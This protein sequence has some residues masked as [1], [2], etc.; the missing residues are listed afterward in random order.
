MTFPAEFDPS[1]CVLFLGSGF[2]AD[3]KN[4]RNQG[5]PVGNGLKNSILT[6]L[7]LPTEQN[8]DD[9]KDVAKYAVSRRV[10]LLRLLQELYTIT[11]INPNQETILAKNWRRIY[12]TNYDDIVEFSGKKSGIL[13]A[14]KSFSLD[15]QRPAKLPPNSVIHLHGYIHSA[16]RKDYLT[17]LVLDHR[18]YS[19]QAALSSPWWDQFERDIRG[20]QWVFFVGYSLSD[21]AVSK[22]LTKDI[23]LSKATRF[24][25]RPSIND[26]VADRLEGYGAIDTIEVSGFASACASAKSGTPLTELKQLKAFNV[27]DPY[28][29]NKAISRPTPVEIEAFLTRGNYSAHALSSTYPK[30]EFAI[31][32][33]DEIASAQAKLADVRTLVL[34]SRTANGK[35]I[36]AEMLGLALTNAG[37]TCVRYKSHASIPPE[38]I[39]FLSKLP[40]L[41]VFVQ[42]YDDAVEI[43]DQL[44][45]LGDTVKFIVEINTGTDQVRRSEVQGAL[46]K[47]VDRQDLNRLTKLDVSNFQSLLDRAG[48]PIKDFEKSQLLNPELRD[49]L[50]DLLKSEHVR[51]RI[52][53]VIQPLMED[54]EALKIVATACV[55]KAFSIHAGADFIRSVTG[56]DPYGILFENKLLTIEI[57]DVTPDHLAFH[58]AVFC[59]F[60]LKEYVGGTRIRAV[61]CRLAFEAARRK[62]DGDFKNSQRTREARKALGS[63]VQYGRISSLFEGMSDGEKYVTETFEAL[64]DNIYINQEPLFWLQ[65]SIFMQDKSEYGI[66]RKHLETA[67]LRAEASDG[68]RTFQLDTNYLKLIL[69]APKGEDGFP[70]DTEVIF[71]LLDKVKA[72]VLS[73]DHRVHAL[74]VLEDLKTFSINHGPTITAG[75]RQKLSLQCLSISQDLNGLGIEMKTEFGTD[76][77]RFIVED[78]IGI[79]AEI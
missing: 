36:F 12:T 45:E 33:T 3:A 63:L 71:D 60:L 25:M 32:R 15:D 28:K 5:P 46:V 48:L 59:E 49:I 10:D 13:P 6:E 2:S 40:N 34:H 9:L 65:Y 51:T 29:D 64:R 44:H 4:K 11:D 23:S 42:T 76:K 69:Q 55:L 75:E 68:F 50:L 17:Q 26:M 30:I 53:T 67:Y 62:H 74:R 79:L 61:I 78:A 39:T 31:P 7:K 47:P 24:I 52:K 38:E 35:S 14:R 37:G 8:T 57:G 27:I 43:S 73:E 70:G 20:A 77:T 54:R 22:Y 66:A 72:M 16:T 19:E 56:S 1:R 58:S 18:S 21:F 41:Y